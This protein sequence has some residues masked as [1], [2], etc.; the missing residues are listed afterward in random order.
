MLQQ[1]HPEDFAITTGKQYSVRDFI[2]AAT[3]EIGVTLRFEGQ[4]IEE[5]GIVETVTGDNIIKTGDIIVEADPTYF[6]PAEVETLL[7]NHET[8]CER[9]GW[10]TDIS[11]H[12][13]DQEMI[14]HD[15]EEA[16]N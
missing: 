4:G 6:F 13:M 2:K 5:R 7:G 3:A 10:E 15:I 14:A 8:T 12:N 1:E 11:L 16:K 9:L